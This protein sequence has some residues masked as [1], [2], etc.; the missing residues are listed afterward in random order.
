[1]YEVK[2]SICED[3]YIGNT[4]LTLKKMIDS[5]FFDR[6]RLLKNGQKSD[7]LAA[8]L[9]QHFNSTKSRIDIRKC[10]TYK[11]VKQI[12]PIVTMKTFTKPKC[13]VCMKERLMI[14]KQLRDKRVTFMNKKLVMYGACR[15]KT[16]FRQFFLSTDDT[17]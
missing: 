8:H 7:S 16:N 5:H 2:C 10:I 9:E 4:Q 17:T 13:N 12:N 15:H 3:V 6:L 11:I 1:M 14:L